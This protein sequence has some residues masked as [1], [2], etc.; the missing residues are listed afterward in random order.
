MVH[1][2]GRDVIYDE[3]SHRDSTDGFP[4][5]V[6]IICEYAR[7]QTIRGVCRKCNGFFPRLI[8][9][10]CDAGGEEFSGVHLHCRGGVFHHCWL[11]DGTFTAATGATDSTCC[12]GICD[13]FFCS[14]RCKFANH[15]PHVGLR[16]RRVAGD[17]T[18]CMFTEEK[19][20]L[21][22]DRMVHEHPLDR[23]AGLPA[24]R[25]GT[26]RNPGSGIGEIRILMHDDCRIATQFKGHAGCMR[27]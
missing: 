5:T 2:E 16:N 19:P 14:N 21:I 6:E 10:Q 3:T 25:E 23:D 1:P 22:I 11:Q 26:V 9:H 13:L 24:V 18:C 17:K 20:H 12:N 8:R 27:H 7:L 4:D 15:R